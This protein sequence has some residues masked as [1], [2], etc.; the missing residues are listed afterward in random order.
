MQTRQEKADEAAEAKVEAAA[1]A[2]AAAEAHAH[3]GH[4]KADE[5]RRER[6]LM[7]LYDHMK[8]AHYNEVIEAARA[9]LD[10][11]KDG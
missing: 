8:G 9:T 5:E 4:S 11:L 2:E 1:V 7:K 10:F 3:H 6:V